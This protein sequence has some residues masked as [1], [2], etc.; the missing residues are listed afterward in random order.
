MKTLFN[1]QLMILIVLLTV[2]LF[3][4]CSKSDLVEETDPLEVTNPEAVDINTYIQNLT[5]N[6]QDLLNT[7]NIDDLPSKRTENTKSKTH[8][9]DK[10]KI[11][12]CVTKDYGLQSNFSDIAILKP[13]NGVLYPG[14]LVYGNGNML[15]GLPDPISI[16]RGPMILSVDLP[17]IGDKG[18]MLVKEPS[19]SSVQAELD[20][21]LEYWNENTYDGGYTI[22]S[23]SSSVTATFFSSEQMS[24]DLGMNVKWAGNSV[25]SQLNI[26]SSSQRKV[27]TKVFKQIFYTVSMNTPLEKSSVFRNDVTLSDIQ[28]AVD[29]DNPPAYVSSV[30]Y[31]RIIM[32]KIESNS[33]DLSVDLEAVLD[34]ASSE[35]E[36]DSEY[37]QILRSSSVTVVTIGGNAEATSELNN[38]G[39]NQ[40]GNGYLM[41]VITG[42]NAVY[43]RDNPGLPISYTI[44]YLK[45][46]AL[47]KMGYSTSYSYTDCGKKDFDHQDIK[48]T[49]DLKSYNA[50]VKIH[51]KYIDEAGKERSI[52]GEWVTVKD[53]SNKTISI[54]NGAWGVEVEIERTEGFGTG[55][56]NMQTKFFDHVE[57][58][59]CFTLYRASGTGNNIRIKDEEC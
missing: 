47:A 27:A 36:V 34:Y 51:Y 29:S 20:K 2:V 49:N 52:N 4:G 13:H 50:Y 37:D 9:P 19:N 15:D 10:G 22:A 12:T 1:L 56:K 17:G 21:A 35:S 42:K 24:M 30:S 48:V 31:G 26:S 3:M 5:Y 45:D 43:G 6:P 18:T 58:R 25:A 14:A 44:R 8:D 57:K 54:P 39:T 11:E 32:V 7:Q 28:N 38:I 16:Y 59:H 55:R 40:Q 23:Q 53:E 41:D 46:N 33:S